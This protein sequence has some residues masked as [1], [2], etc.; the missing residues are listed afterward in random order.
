MASR[1][2]GNADRTLAMGGSGGTTRPSMA[3]QA[4]GGVVKARQLVSYGIISYYYSIYDLPS[5]FI[6]IAPVARFFHP[7]DLLTLLFFSLS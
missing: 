6:A 2:G 5:G 7:A 4:S 1:G 3:P